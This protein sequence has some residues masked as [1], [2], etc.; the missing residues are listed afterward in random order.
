MIVEN[1]TRCLAINKG[2]VYLSLSLDACPPV[3]RGG[4]EGEG[5]YIFE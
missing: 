3:G 5:E 2:W 4:G 1:Y